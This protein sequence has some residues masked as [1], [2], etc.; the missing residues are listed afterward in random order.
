VRTATHPRFL[1]A[2]VAGIVDL[3][4]VAQATGPVLGAAPVAPDAI[5]ATGGGEAPVIPMARALTGTG[6][7]FAGAVVALLDIGQLHAAASRGAAAFDAVASLHALDGRLLAADAPPG[8][9]RDAAGAERWFLR[10]PL[11]SGQAWSFTGVDGRHRHLTAGIAV[12]R[13][14]PLIVEVHQD[15]AVVQQHARDHARTAAVTTGSVVVAGLALIGLLARSRQIGAE[16]QAK[17]QAVL[18]DQRRSHA[19]L[20]V[21]IAAMPGT[22]MRIE[23]AQDGWRSTYI[24]PSFAGLTGSPAHRIAADWLAARTDAGSVAAFDAALRRA[25]EGGDASVELLLH[26]GDGTERRVAV[27]MSAGAPAED[28]PE[29]VCV[30]SDVTRER[31]LERQLVHANKMAQLGEVATGVA[32]ELNQPLTAISMAAENA[33]SLLARPWQDADRLRGKLE[34]VVA[35]ITRARDV[36]DH[37]RIF[38]RTDTASV[39]PVELEQAVRKAAAL[40]GERL[41]R[42]EVA[43][44]LLFPPDP[45]RVLAKEVPLEQVM[46]NLLAN[47]CD[48]YLQR[49]QPGPRPVRVAVAEEGGF[50][51]LTVQDRA[52]GIPPEILE[53]IFEPFFTTKPVGK[54]TGLGLSLSFGIVADLG[55]TLAAANRDGGALFTIRLPL[56]PPG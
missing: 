33:L 49:A 19:E 47:A 42:A 2:S 52:G 48:A 51:V 53:R 38:G 43:V 5:A 54:G 41:R 13:V 25:A 12:T 28:R 56:A 15:Q 45:P 29:V 16:A 30:W 36:M 37:M 55:G 46:I 1:G 9:A 10:A 21:L 32:H 6:G 18:A 40:V 7:T 4:L 34:T 17:L 8:A 35:M 50:A 26:H 27:R 11:V 23:P 39:A 3:G 24:A 14:I 44:T 22:L 31:E 20:Q